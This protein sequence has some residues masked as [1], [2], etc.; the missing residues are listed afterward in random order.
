MTSSPSNSA[1]A[2]D[3]DLADPQV[4]ANLFEQ[5]SEVLLNAPGRV[6]CVVEL[7]SAGRLVMT[8]DLHDNGYNFQRIV[9]FA[10][11]RKPTNHLILHEIIHG[12]NPVNGCDISVR[13]L[14]RV[15]A[16]ILDHPN[17]VTLML[18]NHELAQLNGESISK[19]VH[20]MVD[21]FDA[22]LA[23]LFGDQADTVNRAMKSLIRSL[24]LGVR[25]P[26][27]IFCCHSIPSPNKL[28]T[29]DRTLLQ[30]TPTEQ[31]LATDGSAH[32]MVWGRRHTQELADELA[33]AW[34]VKVFVMGHQPADMGHEI[35]GDTMLI[36]ASN[37]THGVALPIDLARTYTR[38]EL[39]DE[40]MPLAAIT[41]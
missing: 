19:G 41:L 10:N 20:N 6:G 35:E 25:L 4:V 21:D 34:G 29:F 8:G 33:S 2:R 40:L 16:L 22:G 24:P 9:K 7:P 28:S 1:S 18:A 15:A 39:V 13:T 31:D 17:Q 12:P 27:G 37:H 26:N 38:D 14:A 32:L 3:L 23:F 5:A 36:L 30:R 11:L